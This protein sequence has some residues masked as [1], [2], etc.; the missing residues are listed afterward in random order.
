MIT[1]RCLFLSGA[2]VVLVSAAGPSGTLY[3]QVPPPP[4]G[5][6]K[7]EAEEIYFSANALY[8]RKLYELATREYLSF[9]KKHPQHEKAP[10]AR[11]GLALSYYAMGQYAEAEPLLAAARKEI[12]GDEIQQVSVLLGQCLLK[13]KRYPEAEKACRQAVQQNKG[14]DKADALV[15]LAE[16]L[17]Q[18]Q[19]W[20]EV[21]QSAEGL[22]KT[23]PEHRNVLRVRFQGALARYRL[24]QFAESAGALE[25]LVKLPDAGSLAHQAKFLLA[26]CRRELGDLDK[27]AEQYAAASQDKDG[28]FSPES[29]FRLGFVRFSQE[30]YDEAVLHLKAFVDANPDSE[31]TPKAK[32]YL[33]QAY[34]ETKA[35]D[36]AEAM[37]KPLTEIAAPPPEAVVWLARTYSRREQMEPAAAVLERGLPHAAATPHLPGML[38]DLGHARLALNQPAEAAQAFGRIVTEFAAWEQTP[39]AL[40]LKALAQHRAEDFAGSLAT[41]TAFLAEQKKH[42][43]VAEVA[44]MQA[45]NLLLLERDKEA[46]KAY[47]SFL[48][49]NGEHIS[50]NAARFRL[51]QLLHKEGNWEA[52]LTE[53]RSLVEKNLKE[54]LFRQLPFLVGDAA[55]NL[56]RMDEAVKYLQVFADSPSEA[57]NHDVA[58]LKLGLAHSRRSESKAAIEALQKLATTFPESPQRPIGLVELGR[59][60]YEAKQYAE[61]RKVFLDVAASKN[62]TPPTLAQGEYYLGWIDLAE[63]KDADAGAHFRTVAEKHGESPL[64]ADALLQLGNVQ[65]KA[66]QFAEAE[67][68]LSRL[69]ADFKDYGKADHVA[70]SLGIAL[71]R[72]EKWK[73]AASSFDA[74]I[75]RREPSALRD[76]ALY[77][78]A[79]CDKRL[80]QPE[81]AIKTYGLL[82]K[83]FPEGELYNRA[84]FELAELEFEAERYDDAIQRIEALLPNVKDTDLRE[85]A[86]YRLGWSTFSKEDFKKSAEAFESLLKEFPETEFTAPAAYQA[87]EARMKLKENE[88][89]R[90]HFQTASSQ[91]EAKDVHELALLRL[92]ETQSL[93]EQWPAAEQAFQTFMQTYPQSEWTRRALLGL[94]WARENQKQYAEAIE[95]YSQVTASAHRDETAARCQF[96]IGECR[97]AMQQYDEAI[98]ALIKVSV[99]YGYPKWSAKALLETGRALEQKGQLDRAKAQYEEVVKEYPETDAASVARERLDSLTP[100]Q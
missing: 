69:A 55:F 29:L 5:I 10:R 45:E 79:W 67:A 66:G 23:D 94:G 1:H 34:L 62:A 54:D 75:Q 19:K 33:G 92:G 71:A 32:L 20:A 35:Y 49:N 63:G 70:H 38:F 91:T 25:A 97:F 39:D 72:Q 93:T 50:A 74:V 98:Q 7:K 78:R 22:L 44:F 81:A 83:D 2:L 37:L 8:N 76:R 57:S 89:A 24:K 41:C 14:A 26:E 21:I 84:V 65:L 43:R 31:L 27:A 15:G 17:F 16:A 47:R 48:E 86:L 90:A 99:A 58:L 68:T 56:E 3:G 73:E 61:A 18:Q 28:S 85:Q 12:K 13:L 6:H 100:S 88:A 87:G 36:Q 64:A 30:K 52:A 46:L 9:L 96:Q 53:S 80:G 59:L 42:P 40:Y 51:A 11:L 82:I 77:E 4:G 60:Q 95:A